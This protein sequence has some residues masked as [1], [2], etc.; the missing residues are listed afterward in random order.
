MQSSARI[1]TNWSVTRNN[2]SQVFTLS[3]EKSR[4]F[5]IKVN[6]N[7]N[8][9]FFRSCHS[10]GSLDPFVPKGKTKTLKCLVFFPCSCSVVTAISVCYHICSRLVVVVVYA[11]E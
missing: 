7:T 4:D 11:S 10:A 9:T 3:L 2:I 8:P 6:G 1:H 5:T